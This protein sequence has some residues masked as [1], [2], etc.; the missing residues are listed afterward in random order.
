MGHV[1]PPHFFTQVAVSI[2]G[3]GRFVKVQVGVA[4]IAAWLGGGAVQGEPGGDAESGS[5]PVG[6]GLRRM[7]HTSFRKLVRDRG[8]ACPGDHGIHPPLGGV[9]LAPV[10]QVWPAA[11]MSEHVVGAAGVVPAAL[12]VLR[13]ALGCPARF[14]GD[15]ANLVVGGGHVQKM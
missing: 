11:P 4:L 8:G 2:D 9:H 14:S 3:P 15:P 6:V 12:S 5:Q 7:D 13:R 1:E 10:P